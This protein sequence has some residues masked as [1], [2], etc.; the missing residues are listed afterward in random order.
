MESITLARCA[1]PEHVPPHRMARS[2]DLM[3]GER[4]HPTQSTM[5]AGDPACHRAGDP[6]TPAR[7]LERAMPPAAAPETFYGVGSLQQENV[8]M[9]VDVRS[10]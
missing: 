7:S 4:G 6:S 10:M 2:G 1:V 3:A 8:D 5:V 9:N